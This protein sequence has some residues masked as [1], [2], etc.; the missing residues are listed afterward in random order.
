MFELREGSGD[1]SS[2][3]SHGARDPRAF[4][5]T[6]CSVFHIA[7]AQNRASSRRVRQARQGPRRRRRHGRAARRRARGRPV[8]PPAAQPRRVPLRL[9]GV[10][11][12][13]LRADLLPL[14]V[15]GVFISMLTE[16]TLPDFFRRPSTGPKIASKLDYVGDEDF[17]YVQDCCNGL[18]LLHYDYVVNPA[19]RRWQ[20]EN[21]AWSRWAVAIQGHTE[22][23]DSYRRR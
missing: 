17:P 21:L 14:S 7:A 10:A 19:T 22:H 2:V 15:R 12:R 6:W 16:A 8:P 20:C 5:R 11:R 18:L 1:V 23:R 13:L 9:P 4:G 3:H